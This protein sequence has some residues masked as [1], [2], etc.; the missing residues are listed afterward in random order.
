MDFDDL[1]VDKNAYEQGIFSNVDYFFS[2]EKYYIN[3]AEFYA[4]IDSQV[5]SYSM[6]FPAEMYN[7]F[8]GNL[9]NLNDL[10]LVSDIEPGLSGSASTLKNFPY[11]GAL[12]WNEDLLDTFF[13]SIKEMNKQIGEGHLK[14]INIRNNLAKVDPDFGA[15][16]DK[17]IKE[18]MKEL[19]LKQRADKIYF[20]SS[21]LDLLNYAVDNNLFEGTDLEVLKRIRDNSDFEINA[22]GWAKFWQ[23]LGV[24]GWSFL[25]GLLKPFEGILDGVVL[26]G[27]GVVDIFDGDGN[28]AS[29]AMLDFLAT[30][31]GAE[32]YDAIIDLC[33]WNYAYSHGWIHTTG[34]S[35]GDCVGDS[36]IFSVSGGT[37]IVINALKKAGEDAQK[38]LGTIDYNNPNDRTKLYL[39]GLK[40]LVLGGGG[41]AAFKATQGLI[42]KS[43][44]YQIL[45]AQG[46]DA[47]AYLYLHGLQGTTNAGIKLYSNYLDRTIDLS[48]YGKS[49]KNVGDDLLKAF[50]QGW[51]SPN[52]NA[53]GDNA[54]DK[55]LTTKGTLNGVSALE[56]FGIDSLGGSINDLSISVTDLIKWSEKI[57]GGIAEGTDDP[58]LD[59][60]SEI[61]TLI[62]KWGLDAGKY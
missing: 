7:A 55:F 24:F 14:I 51:F 42:T 1:E 57:Y 12:E 27:A 21:I 9:P 35:I 19:A 56:N 3:A 11:D 30:D 34:L 45:L 44:R 43:G 52:S 29:N 48:V 36:L 31:W 37:G 50:V 60:T 5:C 53:K 10:N 13:N 8:T 49:D 6:L 38:L 32:G 58:T 61:F 25:Q 46:K 18:L 23:G 54:L 16:Y 28:E 33:G 59:Q 22:D 15:E 47:A 2:A 20:S 17:R 41:K 62:K 26:I 4:T 40:S 39:N